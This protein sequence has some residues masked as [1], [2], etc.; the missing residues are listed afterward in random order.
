[1]ALFAVLGVLFAVPFMKSA[2]AQEVKSNT[3]INVSVCYPTVYPAPTISSPEDGAKTT[4]STILVMGEATPNISVFVFNNGMQVAKVIADEGGIYVVSVGLQV[5]N[6]SIRASTNNDC[7]P[8]EYSDTVNV[9]RKTPVAPPI[10][11]APGSGQPQTENPD[12]TG[13]PVIPPP[14]TLPPVEMPVGTDTPTGKPRSS[15][16]PVILS[17]IGEVRVTEPSV[18]IVGYAEPGTKV[19]IIRGED[20]VAEVTAGSDGRFA[21]RIPLKSGLNKIYVQIGSGGNLKKSN[22]VLVTY[23]PVVI[24]QQ[25][26]TWPSMHTIIA[27]ATIAVVWLT[28]YA[29]FGGYGPFAHIAHRF[30]ERFHKPKFGRFKWH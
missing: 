27:G 30:F 28:L 14:L 19:K 13:E 9:E 3:N 26:R 25:N 1:M 15:G 6:N 23:E 16:W 8:P 29:L 17:P 12:E 24:A 7:H 2:A 18:L 4:E 5:G 21:A 22:P 11:P 10:V 20:T